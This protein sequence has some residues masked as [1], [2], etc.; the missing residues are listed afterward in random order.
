MR[1]LGARN[2]AWILGALGLL[3][4]ALGWFVDPTRFAFAWVAAL[5]TWMGWP[6]GCL[7]L[8][9][10]HALTGG[11][12]GDAIRPALHAGLGTLPLLLP[13]LV[14]V[15]L[16]AGRLYPWMRPDVAADLH[17]TFYLN[18]TFAAVRWLV[19]VVAWFGLAAL[20]LAG[21]NRG[22]P[23]RGLAAFTLIVLGYTVTFAAIDL[24]VSLE[25][26][27]KSSEYGMIIGAQDALFALAVTLWL[28]TAIL[29]PP[30]TALPDL[31]RILFGLLILWGY[32]DFMQL[33]IIWQSDLPHE[34]AWYVR[35]I[36]GPWGAL[37]VVLALL[38][39]ALPFFALLSPRLRRS[40]RGIGAV[41]VLLIVMEILRG[42]WLVLPAHDLSPNWIDLAA[43]LAFG[44]CS[45]ALAL[46]RPPL[47]RAARHH[48]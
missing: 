23:S 40:P 13:A 37:T 47:V 20:V 17:N 31:G 28:V 2:W 35:R 34:A 6:L 43:M 12:W 48:A 1:D 21:R 46:P 15:L 5:A 42:W 11:R 3:L 30:L 7:A 9:C 14:P 44:G 38:H 10:V 18:P 32:L 36:D 39:F 41:A 45:V 24:L 16:L 8:L 33:L 25:P 22:G 19:F 4:A 26:H 29:P 27:F